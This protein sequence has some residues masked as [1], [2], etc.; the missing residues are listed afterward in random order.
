MESHQLYNNTDLFQYDEAYPV[1][2]TFFGKVLRPFQMFRLMAKLR[3]NGYDL[4]VYL[5]PSNRN[6]RN[7]KRDQRFF[8]L[9]GIK[10][11]IGMEGF[12]KI[13]PKKPG[14]PLLELPRESDLLMARLAAAGIEVPAPGRGDMDL[15]LGVEEFR[16]VQS[17]LRQQNSDGD[18]VWIGIGPGSKM[19]SKR[20]PMDRYV[21]VVRRLIESSDIWPVIFG[22]PEDRNLGKKMIEELGCGY[23]AAGKLNVRESA[24]ALSRCAI[25]LGNDTGTMHLAAS[26]KIPCVAIFSAREDP[27]LWYPYGETHKVFRV[28]IE[29]EGCMLEECLERHNE[30]INRIGAEEVFEACYE[31]LYPILTE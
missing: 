10:R 7:V 31:M 30:C 14:M 6:Q 26:V 16:N 2:D 3:H 15:H 24:A 4:L 27:G 22:G 25:Y 20:W 17:W 1:I 9:S 8:R 5:T 11:F 13:I 21:K 19:P 18:R 29:C 28:V 12:P 23:V